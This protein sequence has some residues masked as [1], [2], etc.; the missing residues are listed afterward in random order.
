MSDMPW[1][2]FYPNDWLAGT[3]GLSAVETGIYITL[4]ATMYDRAAPIPND[5]GML[6]RLCGCSQRQFKAAVDHLVDANKL[7]VS[8]T[9]IWN[10]RVADELQAREVKSVKAKSSA[11]SRWWKNN[12]QKQQKTDATAH[13]TQC[14]TDAS[15]KSEV[16]SQKSDS[17]ADAK[18]DAPPQSICV[19]LGQRITDRM[20]VTN[21]PRWMGNWSIVSVWLSQGYDPELDVW[22]AVSA[23]V[24]RKK[25]TGQKMPGSLSYF[26]NAIADHHKRRSEG[27]RVPPA[28]G[29]N[30]EV[31]LVKRGS[32]EFRAW[33]AHYKSRGMRTKFLEEQSEITVPSKTPPQHSQAAA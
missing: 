9:G 3:R 22:P 10:Q 31:F 7:I 1:F 16:R 24:D 20:G 26:T 12:K 17:L 23:I 30:Q 5:I 19:E 32:P 15:Q 33:I 18:Q 27:G 13:Q 28:V 2:Q 29:S 11:E 6:S 14:E 4:I 21:D 8:E 25:A